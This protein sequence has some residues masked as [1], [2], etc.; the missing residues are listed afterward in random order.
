[1]LHIH[2]H[3]CGICYTDFLLWSPELVS[4]DN[5]KFSNCSAKDEYLALVLIARSLLVQTPTGETW[6]TVIFWPL[7]QIG[8]QESRRNTPSGV[9]APESTY[10]L[11]RW[12]VTYL[13]KDVSHETPDVTP[14][15]T[16]PPMPLVRTRLARNAW[17]NT[18]SHLTAAGCTTFSTHASWLVRSLGDQVRRRVPERMSPLRVFVCKHLYHLYGLYDNWSVSNLCHSLILGICL[19]KTLRSPDFE[20]VDW[21][22]VSFHPE[23]GFPSGIT[24]WTNDSPADFLLC[25]P[26]AYPSENP[27]D[28]S[29]AKKV[30]CDMMFKALV[31]FVSPLE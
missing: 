28:R 4:T 21:P 9:F 25:S 12:G 24:G 23:I 2:T 17:C 19:G 31:L 13:F 7:G 8:I 11:W 29:Q 30:L 27:W 5:N 16:S 26:G 18:I 15:R 3:V 20:F 1:M 14:C 6:L 10:S 22:H